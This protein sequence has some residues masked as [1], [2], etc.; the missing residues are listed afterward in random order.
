MKKVL[1]LL[2]HSIIFY[3]LFNILIFKIEIQK[4]ILLE[5]LLGVV[6]FSSMYI[7]HKHLDE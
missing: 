6:L 3:L 4:Y 7:K 1:L 5:I 2:L